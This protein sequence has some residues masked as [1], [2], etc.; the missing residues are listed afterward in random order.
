MLILAESSGRVNLRLTADWLGSDLHVT[1]TGGDRPHIGA[2][3][4]AQPRPSL[5]DAENISASCSVLTLCGHKEDELA[6]HLALAL[7]ATLNTVVCVTCGIHLD[8]ITP[9]EI[10]EVS[11]LS[12]AMIQ[13]IRPQR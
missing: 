7:A 1:L 10:R 8:A 9:D 11:R 5:C 4:L 6:R 3:A 2:V 13:V 12:D